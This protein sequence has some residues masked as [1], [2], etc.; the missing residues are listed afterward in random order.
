MVLKAT[1]SIDPI[2][3]GESWV[4]RYLASRQI[5]DRAMLTLLKP[6]MST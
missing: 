2:L 3:A 4:F 6:T 5:L 1:I